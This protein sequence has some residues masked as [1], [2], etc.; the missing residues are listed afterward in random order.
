MKK[1]V[2]DLL[3][4]YQDDSVELSGKTPLSSARIKELTMKRTEPNRKKLYRL[5]LRLL[6]AAAIVAAL[7]ASTFAVVHIAGAGELMQGFFARES[8]P[9]SSGQIQTMDQI[10][11]TFGEGATSNGATIT[12]IAAVASENAYYLRLRVEAPE[13][14]TLPDRDSDA[15]GYYQL[16][17]Q[18]WPEEEMTLTFEDG[19]GV[20]GYTYDLEWQPDDNPMDNVKE[21]VIR[22]SSAGI[23]PAAFNDGTAK[24]LTIHG[25]WVQSSYHEYTPVFTGEFVF[26]VGSQFESGDIHIDCG[27]MPHQVTDGYVNYLDAIT[28]S[29]ID[30]SYTF[31]TTLRSDNALGMTPAVPGEIRIVMKDG[32][33]YYA[34]DYR[35]ANNPHQ[36]IPGF[37]PDTMIADGPYGYLNSPYWT[38]NEHDVFAQPLDLSQVDH[39]L[40]DGEYVFPINAD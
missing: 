33:E 14:V 5:P 32:S 6:A 10:G 39:I 31:R 3:D 28:L 2:S 17:G 7:T 9:L 25:L 40:F 26:E 11:R 13:G 27:G 18:R 29:P 37:D 12:P 38:I 23:E 34:F 21:V 22:Y 1:R 36:P 35:E 24:Y 30:I 4:A 20:N 19:E 8:G 15:D 16:S